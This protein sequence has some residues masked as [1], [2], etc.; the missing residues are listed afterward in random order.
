MIEKL[1]WYNFLLP[2][3]SPQNVTAML[4]LHGSSS[5]A[6]QK[7]CHCEAAPSALL[8]RTKK[9]NDIYR[10]VNPNLFPKCPS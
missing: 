10:L 9:M 4:G 2:I 7:Y 1:Q 5:I 3:A 6:S 8:T